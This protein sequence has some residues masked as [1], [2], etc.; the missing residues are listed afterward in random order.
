MV[1]LEGTLWMPQQCWNHVSSGKVTLGNMECVAHRQ[2][3]VKDTSLYSGP[4]LGLWRVTSEMRIYKLWQGQSEGHDSTG[5]AQALKSAARTATL[6]CRY[7]DSP[8]VWLEI[9]MWACSSSCLAFFL[10]QTPSSYCPR[11]ALNYSAFQIHFK[12]ISSSNL[13]GKGGSILLYMNWIW[14]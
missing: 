3:C 11:K 13:K 9:S 5:T 14:Q 8:W 1:P 10:F 12:Y 2:G 7:V 4:A 6:N